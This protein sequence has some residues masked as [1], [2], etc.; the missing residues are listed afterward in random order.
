MYKI[1]K[2][3]TA[4]IAHIIPN[5]DLSKFQGTEFE[6]KSKVCKCKR[7][8]GHTIKI[9]VCLSNKRLDSSGMV[10]DFNYLKWFKDWIDD[11]L[12]HRFIGNMNDSKAKA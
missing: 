10:I 5:Q 2:Q 6:C 3:F 1:V 11:T 4:D 8:H 7:I 9:E 12:D